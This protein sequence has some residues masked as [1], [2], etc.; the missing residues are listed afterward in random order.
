MRF[1]LLR[2]NLDSSRRTISYQNLLLV[3]SLA[4]NLV[5]AARSRSG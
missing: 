5:T 4:L 3:A 1:A 2:Q